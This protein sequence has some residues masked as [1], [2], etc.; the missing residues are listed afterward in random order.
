MKQNIHS[1]RKDQRGITLVVVLLLLVIVTLLG[2]AAMRGTVMQ[3]RMSGN[4][5]A[6]S[7]AFQAAE[8]LLREAEFQAAGNPS[9]PASGCSNG[10]CAMPTAGAASAWEAAGFWT[11]AGGYRTSSSLEADPIAAARYVIEFM[12]EG[13]AGP[14]ECTSDIDLSAPTCTST[15]GGAN[16][17]RITAFVQTNN[18][19]QVMLQSAYQVP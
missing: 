12:G 10:L 13:L 9:M 14:S 15:G 16:N 11:T 1:P 3:E 4:A 17:F 18:G 5:A 7:I 6:R 8:A 19:A 2:L